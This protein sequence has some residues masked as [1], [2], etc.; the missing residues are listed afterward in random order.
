[1]PGCGS[2][3]IRDLALDPNDA[4]AGLDREAG[5]AVEA[6]YRMDAALD[7]HDLEGLE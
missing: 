6:R 4:E 1:V 3:E 2:R 7:G 5:L